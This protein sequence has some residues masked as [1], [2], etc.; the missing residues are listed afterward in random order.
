MTDYTW[1][2]GNS[3]TMMIRDTNPGG[4]SG[5][6][7]FWINS[8]NSS[9][10]TDHLPWTYSLTPTIH[11][12]GSFYYHPGSGWQRLGVWNI[13]QTNIATFGI[14][15]T[16][17]S[18]FGGPTT[19]AVTIQRSTVPG[20]PGVTTFSSIT[21]TSVVVT[22]ADGSNGGAAIDNHQVVYGTG[23]NLA[24][25]NLNIGFTGSGNVTGLT[26][27]TTYYFWG[28]THNRNG[29]GAFSARSQVTTLNVPDAPSTP[30]ISNVQPTSV[31]LMWTPNGTGGSPIT[32]FQVGYSASA[33]LPP[34]TIVSATS[35]KTISGL[36]PGTTYYFWV[37]A[38]NAIGFS[39]WSGVASNQ[40]IAGA[41]IKVAGVWKIAIPYVRSGGV[42]KHAIPWAKTAGEWKETV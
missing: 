32:G 7:E 41:R 13:T 22:F 18:G 10:W 34:G 12:S 37:R 27:G 35:P 38:Q 25:A 20:A 3:A 26:P 24:D 31:D 23:P 36:T 1:P 30:V 5:N 15:N 28:R 16:G 9:T 17:T 4:S 14:G 2:T 19:H 33:S 21:S 29:W 39:E 8:N 40:T 11:G 6:V 42:W